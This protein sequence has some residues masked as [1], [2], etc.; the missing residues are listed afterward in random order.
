MPAFQRLQAKRLAVQPFAF[1]H[2]FKQQLQI[3]AGNHLAPGFLHCQRR[4]YAK[5]C[6]PQEV[7]QKNDIVL[8]IQCVDGLLKLRSQQGRG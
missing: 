6:P 2:H 3:S 1:Q 8:S 5:G 4:G 7:G